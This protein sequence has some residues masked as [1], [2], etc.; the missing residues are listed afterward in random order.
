MSHAKGRL[1][2]AN[3]STSSGMQSASGG[4][5]RRSR[6][7]SVPPQSTSTLRSHTSHGTSRGGMQGAIQLG[8]HGTSQVGTHGNSQVGT[9]GT[10]AH[11]MNSGHIEQGH[12][13]TKKTSKT[14]A[15]TADTTPTPNQLARMLCRVCR[16]HSFSPAIF[17]PYSWLHIHI[18]IIMVLPFAEI[19]IYS[20]SPS[21]PYEISSYC[22]IFHM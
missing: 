13:A 11:W 7:T 10:H 17:H 5:G 14:R 16:W 18:S 2:L 20:P 9:H 21:T 4:Q 22:L 6:N 15:P 12:G 1:A 19:K 8:T 3:G